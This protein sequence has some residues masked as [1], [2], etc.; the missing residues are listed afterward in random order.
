MGSIDISFDALLNQLKLFAASADESAKNS[1]RIA[2][3][4][5]EYTLEG[6]NDTI[7]RFGYYVMLNIVLGQLAG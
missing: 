1:L 4:D 2:L 5:F 6:P 3:R 7:N